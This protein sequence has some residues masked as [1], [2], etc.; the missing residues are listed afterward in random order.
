MLIF[1]TGYMGA[2]KTTL[3]RQLAERLNYQFYDLDEMIETSTGY[4]ILHYFE[5]F[6]EDSFRDK[7]REILLSHLDDRLTVIA[8]GGGTACYI[9]NMKLMNRKGKTIFIDTKLDTILV[10]LAVKINQ[11]PLLRN[12]PAEQLPVFIREHIK[13]RY[14]FYSKAMIRVDGEDINLDNLIKALSV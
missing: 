2:G 1:I 14:P 7:E 3:G 8:T 5:K 11:R 9:D 12:I 6:G 10:R 13:S 4:S